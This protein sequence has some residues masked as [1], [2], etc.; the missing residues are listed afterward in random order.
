M[1]GNKEDKRYVKHKAHCFYVL[2]TS[3]RGILEIEFPIFLWN[4]LYDM[5]STI[6]MNLSSTF[7]AES[8]KKDTMSGV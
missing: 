8:R 7:Q 2:F 6:K 5:C 1:G 3:R 4:I